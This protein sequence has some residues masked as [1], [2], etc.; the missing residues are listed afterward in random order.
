MLKSGGLAEFH[1]W[2]ETASTRI[3][4]G[5]ANRISRYAKSGLLDGAPYA[6]AGT[7]FFQLARFAAEWKIVA[8][9][10]MDDP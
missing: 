7:K 1:E 9:A 4:D 2:E 6:G 5:I 8:L 10:W 3:V